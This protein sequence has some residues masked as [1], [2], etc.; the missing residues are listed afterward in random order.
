MDNFLA[1]MFRIRQREADPTANAVPGVPVTT[2][3]GHP[4]NQTEAKGGSYM[5]RIVYTR[6]PQMALTIGAVHRAVELR[7][8]AIGQMPVQYQRKDTEAGNFIM[9]VSRS[10]D[11]YV[12]YGSRM[13][14]LLQVEP[15][16][17]MSASSLWQQVII[18]KLMRGNGFVY[19][20]RNELDEPVAL[21]RATCGGYDYAT[22]TYILTYYTERGVKNKVRVPRQD[23]LHFPNTFRE[24]NG[25]WGI[26]TLRHAYDTMTLI[27][28]EAQQTLETAAK[29]GRIKG[30]ISEKQPAQGAGTLAF[31]L[32]NQQEVQKT[33]K[34]MQDRFHSG[35]DIVSMHGMESFQNI[36]MT[37]QDMQMIEV[38]NMS[39]DDVARY[40]G[41]PRPLL[42]MDTNSH[43]TSY[44]DATM[45]LLSRTVGPDAD[46]MEQ[47]FFRKLLSIEDYGRF[48]IHMCESQLLRMDKETQAKVDQLRLQNGTATVNEL[49]QDW[50]MPI[51]ADGDEPMASANLL[52]L[53]ALIAKSDAAQQLKPGN[54]TVAKPK[55]VE[56]GEHAQ[57]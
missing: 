43:Y 30:I 20:E 49:R 16:P 41:V 52:T 31:G 7:A 22:G 12:S 3:P 27:K 26:S 23:V 5:E 4:S 47:E 48:R 1:N 39:L 54:Y 6:S 14:Y 2:D 42:M 21:W 57:S 50:D 53:K 56:N 28:T 38:L 13:N 25:F 33:A 36:S 40:F 32:L 19:I 15:N 45:E 8:K 37:A 29:G 34:E 35:Q 18:D 17:L 11:G 46:D 24:D 44:R 9:D 55:D 51:V 10:K